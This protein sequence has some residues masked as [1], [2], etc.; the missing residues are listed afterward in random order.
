[1]NKIAVLSISL[2]L[3]A[4]FGLLFSGTV[5]ATGDCTP[6]YGGG[7]N[8]L[9]QSQLIVD[10]KVQSPKTKNFV[11]N[12]NQS[13]GNYIAGDI[14]KFQVT[15]TNKGFFALSKIEVTDSFPN[16]IDHV[17]GPGT[18][19]AKTHILRFTI[20]NLKKNETKLFI[21]TGNIENVSK[22]GCTLNRVEA[23][24]KNIKADDNSAF[25]FDQSACGNDNANITKGGF[26]V[27]DAPK[28]ITQTPATGSEPLPLFSLIPL[29]S[30]GLYL[31]KRSVN[32]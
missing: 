7:E 6:I 27:M 16:L 30:A 9:L 15:V 29:A 20:D 12:L 26:P 4:F 28:G 21:A 13:N 19:D 14:I 5:S 2:I 10:I 11:D 18:Y 23:K 32:N 1:M 3:F 22:S 25:C 8:C 17:S 24:S 31:R